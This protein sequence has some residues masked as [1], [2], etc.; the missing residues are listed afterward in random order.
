LALPGKGLAPGATTHDTAMARSLV[1]SLGERGGFDAEDLV[2]RHLEWFRGEPSDVGTF[3]RRV[4][5]RVSRG[6]KAEDA[7]RA[8]WL[9]RGPEAAAGNGSVA[10]CAPLGAAYANRP[11]R[12]FELAP[13][14]SALTHFDARC[15]SAVLAVTLASAALVRGEPREDAVRT[16]ISSVLDRDGGEEIEYLT[17]AVG[18]RRPIDGP[19]Q[20]FCL[21]AAAAGL[22]A[23]LQD[24]DVEP[25]LLWVV[26]LGGDTSANGAVAG[27][28]LGAASGR[29]GLPAT[30][31]RALRAAT[32]IEAEAERLVPLAAST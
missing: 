27:A 12:L 3:T 5:R 22:Q 9:E 21:F 8:V 1:R 30:W 16:A 15:G 11:G 19:D 26:S 7:A 14:L 28:L 2:A 17:G 24:G 31:L 23:L 29:A 4:L 20:G 10:Y 32:E 18:T 6:A 25:S 13:R